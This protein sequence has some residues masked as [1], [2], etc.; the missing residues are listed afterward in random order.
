MPRAT[1]LYFGDK[2]Y[3]D[4]SVI[5]TPQGIPGFSDETSFLL[6]QIPE[7]HPLVYLQST[8]TPSVCFPGLPVLALHPQY[9]LEI[10]EEDSCMLEVGIRPQIGTEVLAL[11]LLSPAEGG[12]TANLLAPIVVNLARRLALQVVNHIGEYTCRESVEEAVAA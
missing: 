7:Q 12:A 8:R 3:D 2:D 11:T 10:S 5:R 9:E 6:I 4:D 1:T